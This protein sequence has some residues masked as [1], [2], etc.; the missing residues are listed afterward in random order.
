[1]SS[2]PREKYRHGRSY[3]HDVTAFRFHVKQ[4]LTLLQNAW[5]DIIGRFVVSTTGIYITQSDAIHLIYATWLQFIANAY[6]SCLPRTELMRQWVESY[7]TMYNASH[8][9]YNSGMYPTYLFDE[10][11]AMHGSDVVVRYYMLSVK[12]DQPERNQWIHPGQWTDKSWKWEK[13]GRTSIT[14]GR[15]PALRISATT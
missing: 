5:S 2:V 13:T 14:T 12:P 6:I 7:R 11:E 3:G 10:Y 9:W 8:W 1:M 15:C 4:V